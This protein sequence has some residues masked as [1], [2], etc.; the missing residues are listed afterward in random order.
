MLTHTVVNRTTKGVMGAQA[1]AARQLK[2][3]T[4]S[5]FLAGIHL[6]KFKNLVPR[7]YLKA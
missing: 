6:E 7:P 3:S 2:K 1:P 5:G 4:T